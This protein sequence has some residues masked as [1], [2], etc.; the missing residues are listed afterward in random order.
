MR[1]LN[2]V[3]VS[4]WNNLFSLKFQPG[5]PR[6]EFIKESLNP[7]VQIPILSREETY[8]VRE[9]AITL[10]II[11]ISIQIDQEYAEEENRGIRN[12]E[13]YDDFSPFYP[14][15]LMSI[16]GIYQFRWVSLGRK[17]LNIGGYMYTKVVLEISFCSLN[18]ELISLQK[19][20]KLL[21]GWFAVFYYL[22]LKGL[23][24]VGLLS[25]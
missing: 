20:G 6:R 12:K 19:K 21:E 8:S 10:I 11:F 7:S 5:L 15:S 16:D 4:K 24:V 22:F 25:E 2:W 9:K 1:L 13:F 18:L 17:E 14:Y 23:L 3:W